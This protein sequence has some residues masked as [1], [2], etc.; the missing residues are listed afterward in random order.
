ML[1]SSDNSYMYCAANGSDGTN[2]NNY[3]FKMNL[4]LTMQWS[5]AMQN[6]FDPTFA[7]ELDSSGTSLYMGLEQTQWSLLKMQTSD[8]SASY[9]KQIHDSY[10]WNYITLNYNDQ[11]IYGLYDNS[12]ITIF[13]NKFLHQN[14]IA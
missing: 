1:I 4:E 5:K 12:K 13:G 10:T 8:G 14:D 3:I 9:A 2:N 7:F 6:D 11:Y